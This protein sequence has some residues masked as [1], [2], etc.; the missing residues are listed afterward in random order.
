MVHPDADEATGAFCGASRSSFFYAPHPHPSRGAGGPRERAAGR[1]LA[2]GGLPRR[3]PR[4][5]LLEPDPV[6]RLAAEAAVRKLGFEP[7]LA[8]ARIVFVDLAGLGACPCAQGD[9]RGLIIG[10][11]TG[12]PLTA[13]AHAAHGCCTQVMELVALRD[14]PAFR[15]LAVPPALEAARLT[16]R[17]ADVLALVL[18]GA[19]DRRIAAALGI[20]PSTARTHVR[21]VLRKTGAGSRRE[22][23][24][25]DG[26]DVTGARIRWP[27]PV[28]PPVE[29]P[30]ATAPFPL[31]PL[32]P[33]SPSGL[34]ASDAQVRRASPSRSADVAQR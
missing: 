8:P 28:S 34:R 3:R 6:V 22:L 15:V 10:Y 25:R 7:G 33:A 23:R 13:A 30:L 2:G 11:V 12:R 31:A 17:E 26:R 20:A 1:V 24:R 29:M 4:A 16:T 32:A 14:G 27:V 21:A 9:G 5:V 18:A 19:S